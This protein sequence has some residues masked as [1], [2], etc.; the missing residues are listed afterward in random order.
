MSS[1]V[2]R[3]PLG[4]EGGFTLIELLVVILIMGILAA[5]ALPAFLGHRHKAEDVQAKLAARTAAS[6]QETYYTDHDKYT[7]S[8]A[9]LQAI[10]PTLGDPPVPDKP[11][12]PGG[13]DDGYKV[14]VTSKSGNTF[15]VE[16]TT[17]PRK[18]VRT[19]TRDGTDSGGCPSSL[20][21]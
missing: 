4:R 6:A 16:K 5:I 12:I 17:S 15:S 2:T 8:L 13:A 9:D 21:W 14:S 11:V 1:A 10:E 18:F 3:T 7:A 19:C 20:S